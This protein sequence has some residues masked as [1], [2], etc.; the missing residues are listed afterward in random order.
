MRV[1][2]V[3]DDVLHLLI[4][5]RIFETSED[6]VV[7]AKNGQEAL[8]VLK[9]STD[10]H[11]ILT[12]ISMPV[13]DGV[14]LLA[15]LKSNGKTKSIPVIGFTSG[16]VNYYREITKIPFDSLVPKPSDFSDLRLLAQEK[17]KFQVN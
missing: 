11:V 16:D 10:F 14:E 7:T 4:L 2:L 15:K 8:Q 12:D 6:T 9:S 3:D 13:M 17:A 5:K 1:L